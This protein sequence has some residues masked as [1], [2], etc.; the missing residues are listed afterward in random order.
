MTE[1]TEALGEE[2]LATGQEQA[3]E[4][5]NEQPVVE[6]STE[7][8]A[9]E[10]VGEEESGD[11]PKKKGGFQRKIEALTREK[12]EQDQRIQA[13]QQQL[14]DA[15]QQMLRQSQQTQVDD[16]PRLADFGFDEDQ[17]R[18]AVQ[19]W[20]QQKI[21]AFQDQQQQAFQQQQQMAAEQ[22]RM[23]LIQEKTQQ[24]VEKYPDFVAV[25][26]NPSVPSLAKV[27]P[28]A[29]ETLLESDA[30][31]DIAYYLGKNPT[32]IYRFHNLTPVQAVREMTLLEARLKAAPP[33]QVKT[34]PKP[35]TKVSEG[36]SEAV[37]DPNKMDM[38]TWMKWR[39]EQ[40]RKRNQR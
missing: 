39:N 4:S 23:Q 40:V 34:P 15:Q 14:H 38:D 36:S 35:P 9:V 19:Q 37:T 29:F 6:E 27:N 30:G 10:A 25:V 7:T 17:H 21:Q 20:S 5:L 16:M 11:K 24:A 8:E 26:N 32:E 3:P 2:S 1:V 22:R 28:A 31:A 13:M 33:T 12:F 18:A